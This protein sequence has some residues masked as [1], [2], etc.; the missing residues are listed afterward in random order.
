MKHQV[1]VRL[2]PLVADAV[3]QGIALGL[4][5]VFK[6]RSSTTISLDE[7][8]ERSETIENEVLSGLCELIDFDP[9]EHDDA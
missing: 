7:L 5:R 6:H 3:E 9:E 1:R 2:Y 4:R 8:L